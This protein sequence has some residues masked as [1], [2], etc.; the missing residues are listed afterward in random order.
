ML[1]PYATLINT[2]PPMDTITPLFADTCA[3]ALALGIKYVW[4]DTLCIIQDDADDWDREGVKMA[5][6]YQQAWVTVAAT[7]LNSAGGLFRTLEAEEVP[8]VAR[9]PYRNAEGERAGFFYV[10]HL[11]SGSV[12]ESF[13]EGIAESQ[14]R[15]R[16]WVLQESLLSPRVVSFSNIGIFVECRTGRP[17]PGAALGVANVIYDWR[18]Q[19]PLWPVP[20]IPQSLGPYIDEVLSARES[21]HQSWYRLLSRY[22]ALD[23]TRIQKDRLVALAGIANEFGLANAEMEREREESRTRRQRDGGERV[24]LS[25]DNLSLCYASGL[26]INDM[27]QGLLWEQHGSGPP[28]RADALPTWSWASMLS[29]KRNENGDEVLT[30]WKVNWW[31]FWGPLFPLIW[32]ENAVVVPVTTD[33]HGHQQARFD[34]PTTNL[35]ASATAEDRRQEYG[36]RNRFVAL[37]IRGKLLRV[38]SITN[39]GDER[40]KWPP[41]TGRYG[42]RRYSVRLTEGGG[43]SGFASLEHPD[44]QIDRPGSTYTLII[45]RKKKSPPLKPT[46]YVLYI[47]EVETAEAFRPSYERVGTGQIWKTQLQV[48]FPTVEEKRLWLV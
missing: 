29:L 27:A 43:L 17:K 1:S 10:Q 42:C 2:Q 18:T 9:L 14:L 45:A 3:L 47:R 26:W 40:K 6:Y 35:R 4:I 16:G 20:Q 19:L 34:L 12:G 36:N 11:A 41:E 39:N 13:R 21:L 15:T 22:S 25:S 30:G 28:K 31:R 38:N 23:L 37:S 5:S 32:I 48:G 7:V 44:Y 24:G 46:Y 33:V 8:R